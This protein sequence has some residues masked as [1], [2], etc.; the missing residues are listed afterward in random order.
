MYKV[1]LFGYKQS[2]L[3][4][5]KSLK[6]VHE[7]LVVKYESKTT[8]GQLLKAMR[9]HDGNCALYQAFDV[10]CIEKIY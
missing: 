1:W 4:A 8:Y 5:F 7:H 10:I 9:E 2:T 6:Q 3:K